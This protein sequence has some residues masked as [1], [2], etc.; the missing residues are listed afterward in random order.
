[1]LRIKKVNKKTPFDLEQI[2]HY[3]DFLH[4]H[5]V[6]YGDNKADILKAIEYALEIEDKPGGF[7]LIATNKEDQTVGIAVVLNTLMEGFI[8]EHILVYI[9]TDSQQRGQGI[10]TQLIEQ[11]KRETPHSIALHVDKD[12][13]AQNLYERQGFEK[14]YIEMRLKR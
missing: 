3:V 7:L 8:P 13:P 11:L 2:N 5:L 6:P 9:A 14:K 4:H 1:M 12:N 10:G